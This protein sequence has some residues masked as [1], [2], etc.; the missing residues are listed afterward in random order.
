MLN[1]Y[2][3]KKTLLLLLI[4]LGF[5][6]KAQCFKTAAAGY[7][8]TVGIKVDGTLW[9]FGNNTNGQLG[10]GTTVDKN[11]PSKVGTSN[12]WKTVTAGMGH[13]VALKTDGS[14]WAW[15]YGNLGQIG[16]GINTVK[17]YNAIQQ[18]GS[19]KDW[20][21]IAAGAHYTVALKTDGTLWAWGYNEFGQLGDGTTADK[22]IPTQIGIADDWHTIAT[23][24]NHTIA[25]KKDGSLWAWGSNNYGQ[26]GD[27]T[28]IQK[29][30]PTQI[31]TATNWKIIAA[32]Y[33][34]TTAIKAD[35]TLW[36]WGSNNNGQ[37]G[38]GTSI[39]KTIPTQ[40]GLLTSWKTVACGWGNTTAIKTDE[41]L[42]AWGYNRMG[43]LGNGT[44]VNS[45]IPI[46]IGATNDWSM[47]F[48]GNNHTV[49]LKKAGVLWSWGSNS[50]GQLGDATNTER[51]VPTGVACPGG[52]LINT[53]SSNISCS[54]AADGS[55]SVISISGGT[56]PYT[57]LWSN[58]ATTS[59]I[60]KLSAADYSC[61]ITDATS[62]SISKNFTIIEPVA[63]TFK[64]FTEAACNKNNNGNISIT[65]SGG[66]LSYQ[67]AVSPL[68]V[69]QNSPYFANLP[70]GTFTVNV[71]DAQGCITSGSVNVTANIT[72]APASNSQSFNNGAR[73]SDLKAS[74]INI[75][76]FNTLIGGSALNSSTPLQTG[77][78]FVS[79]IINGCESSRTAVDV[80]ITAPSIDVQIPTYGLLA[81]YPFDGNA[82]DFSGNDSHGIAKD[83]TLTSDRFGNNNRAYSFNGTTSNIEADVKNYP[84]KG[85][86]RTIT[87]WFKTD[88]P[89]NSNES[90][91]CI[92][93]YGNVSDPDYWF[94]MSLFSKGYMDIQFDSQTFT[95]QENYFTNEWIFFAMVFDD[96]TNT[97]YA[98]INNVLKLTGAADLYTNGF[99]NFF[100]IGKNKSNNYFEGSIDDIGIWE[101]ALT[102]EEISGLYNSQNNDG[103]YT[104]IPDQKFEQKLINLGIDT[105]GINGKVLKSNA[106][107]VTSLNLNN[108]KIEDLTGIEDF[109][110]LENLLVV[111]DS[112]T[113]L[114][115]SKN[116]K[117]ISLYCQSNKLKN[118][119]ISKNIALTYLNCDDNALNALDIS[120]NTSLE[121]LECSYNAL[122]I[123]DISNNTLLKGLRCNVNNL[124]ILNLKNG[125]NTI[126][127][128]TPNYE[129]NFKDNPNLTC[130]QVD[131]V[132]F[133]NKNWSDSK[134]VIA[135][136]NIFC[137][138]VYSLIPDPLFEQKLIDLGIDNDG[139]NGKISN[140]DIKGVTSLFLS[141]SNITDLSGI[142][143]FTGLKH[144]DCSNNQLTSLDLS[145]NI[146]LETLDASS[147]E[148]TSLDLSKNSKLTV[149]YVVSN[150][151][152][153]LNL[154]NGNNTNMIIHN[155]TGK[156]AASA[157]ATTF[158][159]LNKLECVKVDNASFSNINWSKIK[160]PSTIYS[161]NC[162]LG[163]ED[164]VLDKIALYPNPTK[165]EITITNIVLEKANFY[166]TLGQLVKSFTL[167][168]GNTNNTI[169]LADLPKGVYYV[170]LI[171]QEASSVKKII[172]E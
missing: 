150:P 24:N 155:V 129:V 168:S 125:N 50:Q 166:N 97:F 37:L 103:L 132:S 33:E 42:W 41:T 21:A 148:L 112:L 59:T 105:D 29:N 63:I 89:I 48:C 143:G 6:L 51:N 154:Q 102:I 56:A 164:S 25:L 62:L 165:D 12:D 11:V 90:D 162:T 141:N 170:Y 136:F 146:L 53:V 151:L 10:N 39:N 47:V 91:F 128:T 113:S 157:I 96:Q 27:G 17:P 64:V 20:Q 118:L 66:T 43:K 159:S 84:L 54:G 93:N 161:T 142:E 77:K 106:A 87:G 70:A 104:S 139:L 85:G 8:H 144:L 80:T 74:G 67:Y 152:T 123:L 83:V 49:A 158:L 76:W 163:I 82:N 169:S 65:A 68:F 110:A 134:D 160:E 34:H 18:I 114:D 153:F 171:K 109:T 135:S 111:G 126:L 120:N 35:G 3:M 115:L 88:N 36:V 30:V 60:S 167:N 9:G 149:A 72:D 31:G 5:Q 73:V 145:N 16:N 147:N 58:G 79:Q 75:S 121:Y 122:Q 98:Y 108:E 86:S 32:G 95:S 124:N 131:D 99:G 130:I 81:Y 40:M 44:K 140:A 100:R 46:Q 78:Y 137:K 45:S 2:N 15:G 101:R 69:Y 156:K 138:S 52:L 22:S 119:N 13:T 71:R 107:S 19:S 55:A 172:V 4:L 14:L 57:Y 7:N 26:L 116:I 38:D 28:I 1:F 117:L 94:K 61:I 133:S 92:L 23:N 127:G